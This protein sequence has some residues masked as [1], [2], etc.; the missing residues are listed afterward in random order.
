MPVQKVHGL[1]GCAVILRSPYWGQRRAQERKRRETHERNRTYAHLLC[2]LRGYE[3]KV[4]LTI[5]FK[6]TRVSG[7]PLLFKQ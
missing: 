6:A 4:E 5:D 1:R 3:L 7:L 2:D